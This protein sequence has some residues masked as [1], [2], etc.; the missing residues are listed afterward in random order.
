M[1]ERKKNWVPT[2]YRQEEYTIRRWVFFVLRDAQVRKANDFFPDELHTRA[3]TGKP[4][5]PLSLP[6]LVYRQKKGT[7]ESQEKEKKEKDQWRWE[8]GSSKGK[9]LSALNQDFL[10]FGSRVFGFRSYTVQ[11][12]YGI[13][14]GYP[15]SWIGWLLLV[16]WQ[17]PGAL[18]Q[19]NSAGLPRYEYFAAGFSTYPCHMAFIACLMTAFFALC[20]K[21]IV[22]T[23]LATILRSRIFNLRKVV[24]LWY[25]FCW[26]GA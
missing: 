20:S 15:N 13:T 22:R 4:R 5:K 12:K 21:A 26:I 23:F 19:D 25:C 8:G 7:W 2:S 3:S 11:P 16:F 1:Q 6:G 17:L 9:V 14:K 10:F 18:L 24:L